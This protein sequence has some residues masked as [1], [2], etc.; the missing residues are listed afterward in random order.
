MA[1]EQ[2][3]MNQGNKLVKKVP[4]TEDIFAI[5][6]QL[7]GVNEALSSYVI[8]DDPPVLIDCGAANTSN[9]ILQ[10]LSQLGIQYQ[11]IEK[12]FVSHV[13]LDHAGGAGDLVEKCG[14]SEIYIHKHGVEYITNSEKLGVLKTQAEDA[15]G[16]EGAYGDPKVVPEEVCIPISEGETVE[17]DNHNLQFIHAP[18]HA[19][20]HYAL[21]DQ[22]TEVLFSID[23]AGMFLQNQVLPTTP[24]PSFNLETNIETLNVLLQHKPKVNCY[25]HFGP[26]KI[27]EATEEINEYI[28]ILPEYVE[29][30]K[31]HVEA[32]KDIHEIHEELDSR[33]HSPTTYRDV[34]GV[35]KYL[36][37]C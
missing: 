1:E 27:G 18:G 14:A 19:P 20:H 15:I 6:N 28:K 22:T 25:G 8:A 11:D 7:Y 23:S 21:F 33:W 3:R 9:N 2:D 24:P 16:I 35:L 10:G 26:G 5:D 32:G 34:A 36:E 4:G 13:H 31:K 17:L 29:I 12:I 30:I 37:N